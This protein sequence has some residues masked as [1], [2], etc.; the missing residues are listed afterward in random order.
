MI[1]TP[2]WFAA[3]PTV[4]IWPRPACSKAGR[5]SALQRTSPR[6][7]GQT[8]AISSRCI[9]SSTPLSTT[10]RLAGFA[11]RTPHVSNIAG[12]LEFY[13][14]NGPRGFCALPPPAHRKRLRRRRLPRH[15]RGKMRSLWR[16]ADAPPPP[17]PAAPW[18][19]APRRFTKPPRKPASTCAKPWPT[20][21]IRSGR[22]TPDL[23]ADPGVAVAQRRSLK[24]KEA[25]AQNAPPASRP[26]PPITL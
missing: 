1:R 3:L 13:A 2:F 21:A 5:V 23:T 8:S 25:P 19:M 14:D 12:L 7:A 24:K 11:V 20:S 17:N 18:E 15:A 16:Q 4:A 22:G 10:P 26:P 6:K 9:T